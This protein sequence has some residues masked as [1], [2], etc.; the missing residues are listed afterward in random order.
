MKFKNVTVGST[1]VLHHRTIIVE[2]GDEMRVS[3]VHDDLCARYFA[4]DEEA[5]V[6][7]RC[8]LLGLSSVNMSKKVALCKTKGWNAG[9]EVQVSG[10]AGVASLQG[11]GTGSY[12]RV[13]TSSNE[14]TVSS[15]VEAIKGTKFAIL[16]TS[17]AF[18]KEGLSYT[19]E[20]MSA[21]EKTS[22]KDSGL[23][24]DASCHKTSDL[25]KVLD[26]DFEG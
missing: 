20:H 25:G 7:D 6:L 16:N 2:E 12:T 10:H 21:L 24:V 15:E 17:F 5:L 11:K 3:I 4:E 22:F 26:L 14:K 1:F 18:G 19:A 13:F 9:G 8:R 23:E